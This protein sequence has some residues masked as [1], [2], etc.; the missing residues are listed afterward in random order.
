[1]SSTDFTKAR[2]VL[3]DAES[4]L[5]GVG[6]GA[7]ASGGLNYADPQLV[8]RWYPEY[9][10]LG[11]ATIQEIIGRYWWLQRSNP[12]EYWAFWARHIFHIRYESEALKPYRI[13]YQLMQ[14]R[15]YFI[16]T[17]NVDR[18]LEKAGFPLERIFA[19]QGDYGMFQC[20]R[21]CS[22]TLYDNREMVLNMM[23]HMP[24]P[25]H[26]RAEDV[27]VCPKCGAL[28]VPNLRCD[29]TFVETP[30]LAALPK[31]RGFIEANAPKRMVML[32][33]G[34]GYNTPVIIRFPF[35]QLAAKHPQTCLIR[36]NLGEAGVPERIE[37]NSF[38]F[39]ADIG[40][41]LAKLLAA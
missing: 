12:E 33:L 1:M 14:G 38:S 15:K 27:P 37:R 26:V 4:V 24:D 11:F 28:L 6:A 13:L 7:S 21:P 36:I 18:Q 35:E 32:E 30:H 20:M 25:L 39:S 41:A 9:R 19:P 17:T 29:N 34:V 3:A 16:S 23:K 8:T 31:Y 2:Q 10:A 22:Q 40:Q 5:L